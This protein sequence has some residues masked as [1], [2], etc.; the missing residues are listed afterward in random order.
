MWYR[1]KQ[2]EKRLVQVLRS[3]LEDSGNGTVP[4]LW[5]D[6]DLKVAINTLSHDNR[7]A[8]RYHY[9]DGMS[10]KQ[11]GAFLGISTDAVKS[12]LY[13]ARKKLRKELVIMAKQAP[14]AQIRDTVLSVIDDWVARHAAHDHVLGIA[15]VGDIS[16]NEDNSRETI[17]LLFVTRTGD[18]YPDFGLYERGMIGGSDRG[19]TV[20]P[21]Y[22]TP[23][24]LEAITQSAETF[25]TTFASGRP[26]A[27]ILP[28]SH[29]Y[30]DPEQHL[31]RAVAYARDHRCS[32]PVQPHRK[33]GQSY[34]DRYEVCMAEKDYAAGMWQ[35]QRASWPATRR[36]SENITTPGMRRGICDTCEK[37]P[38]S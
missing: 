27:G 1:P 21:L 35:L 29:I 13:Q 28:Q 9:T 17:Q 5:D 12:R 18:P 6:M 22:V 4:E 37:H 33:A 3:A 32:K 16:Q 23:E 10:C 31:S 19:V 2:Q 38:P 24:K 7:L 26:L 8:V 30:Y 25:Y 36:P 14:V 20:S 15:G 11:I 34:L